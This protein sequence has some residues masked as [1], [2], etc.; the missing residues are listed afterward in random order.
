MIW[1]DQ[2]LENNVALFY[3]KYHGE[4]KGAEMVEHFYNVPREREY[5]GEYMSTTKEWFRIYK[6]N[7][8][9]Y[10]VKISAFDAER[11]LTK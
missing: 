1:E 8:E 4:M 5:V 3:F 10:A 6:H 11:K 7:D 9:F 2:K